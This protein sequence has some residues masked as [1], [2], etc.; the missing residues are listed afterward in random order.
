MDW[1]L[2]DGGEGFAGGMQLLSEHS[3]KARRG[4]KGLSLPC[5]P[6]TLPSPVVTSHCWDE[7][8]SKHPAEELKAPLLSEAKRAGGG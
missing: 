1:A 2:D 7:I 8:S 4:Q 5:F 6:P 3:V